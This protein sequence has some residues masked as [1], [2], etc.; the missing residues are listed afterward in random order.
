MSYKNM[1]RPL[2]E[3]VRFYT[4]F[5]EVFLYNFTSFAGYFLQFSCPIVMSMD[6]MKSQTVI[7]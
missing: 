6:Q 4:D 7:G 1:D 5:C 3:A 2:G